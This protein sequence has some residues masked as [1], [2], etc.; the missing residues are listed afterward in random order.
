MQELFTRDKTGASSKGKFFEREGPPLYINMPPVSG[1]L[2]WVQGLIQR[3]EK[4]YATLGGVLKL[5]EET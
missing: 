3:L 2:A 5:M 1:A 4:P